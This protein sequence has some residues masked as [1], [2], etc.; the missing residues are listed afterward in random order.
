MSLFEDFK[1]NVT[2]FTEN[3]AKKSST[4]IETQKMKLQKSSLES[5]LRDCYVALGRLYE[6]RLASGCDELSDEGRLMEK[7]ASVRSSMA[8]IDEELRKLKGVVRCPG[9]GQYISKEFDFC[10]KCG[11]SVS[12]AA[13]EDAGAEP[14]GAPAEEGSAAPAEGEGAAFADDSAAPEAAVGSAAA[15]D[16]GG[17]AAPADD[18]APKESDGAPDGA[19]EHDIIQE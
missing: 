4:V 18:T 13:P 3:V 1:K 16:D 11:A 5:D 7:L 6:K 10:P 8:H 12:K 17:A 14:D 2:D 9:C 15:Q 19:P